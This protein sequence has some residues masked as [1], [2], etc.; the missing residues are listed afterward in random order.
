MRRTRS[1]QILLV[2]LL[3]GALSAVASESEPE[4]IELIPEEKA[5]WSPR[6]IGAGLSMIFTGPSF[7]YKDK[8]MLVETVPA[9][10]NLALYYIRSNFQKRYERGVAPVRVI[11]PRRIHA[12]S[13][14]VVTV[15]AALPGYLSA[16]RTFRAHALPE[17]LSIQL[18]PLPNSLVSLG[19]THLAGRSTL[20]LR[21][22]EEPELRVSK[23]GGANGFILSFSETAD[24]VEKRPESWGGFVRDVTVDQVGEDLMV[25]IATTERDLQLRSKQ[26]YDP[27]RKEH[28]F[29]LDVMRQGTRPPTRGAV[30]RELERVGFSK[31]DRC[32]AAFES[33][34]RERL[35]PQTLARAF[36][37]SGSIA[38]FYQREAMLRLGRFDGGRVE[39]LS[40]ETF[41]TGSAVELAMALQ[42][43]ARVRGYLALLGSVARTH[44]D[45]AGFIRALT[46]PDMPPEEFAPIYRA[47]QRARA[48][49]S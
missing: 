27:V 32:N 49:C 23:P 34:L 7:W 39:T 24:Q 19:Y 1:L 28:V 20:T 22:S 17:K 5:A 9:H 26:N 13:R 6:N 14:D 46:A 21:T 15:R 29:V 37:P 12:T 40:G 42:S 38:E 47:A 2:C 16:E 10:A 25:R 8:E 48:S 30:R 45:P 44:D 3:S 11:T 4:R 33:V 31:G 36:R 41:R 18:D 35:D 43:A